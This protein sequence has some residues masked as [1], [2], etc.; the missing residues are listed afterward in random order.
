MWNH[1]GWKSC[2][3][4]NYTFSGILSSAGSVKPCV[5][6]PAPSGKAKY[7]WDTDSELVP[8]G[9]GEKYLEQRGEKNLKPYAYKRLE[10]NLFGDSVPFA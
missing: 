4:K 10:P 5:N 1:R 3:S 9:K 7:S 2:K 8:W 6:L